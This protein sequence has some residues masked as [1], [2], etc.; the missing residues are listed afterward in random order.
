MIESE[1]D[2]ILFTIDK[3]VFSNKLPLS[4]N[5]KRRRELMVQVNP[6]K[7]HLGQREE[8]GAK[9]QVQVTVGECTRGTAGCC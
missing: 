4:R 7:E 5:C 1:G 9:A 8:P 3:E 6:R 2:S